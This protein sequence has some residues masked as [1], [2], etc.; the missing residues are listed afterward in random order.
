MKNTFKVS[1]IRD[2]LNQVYN[3]KISF[4]RFVEILNNQVE[5]N[6][7]F[8]IEKFDSTQNWFDWLSQSESNG[9]NEISMSDAIKDI[10]RKVNEIVDLINTLTK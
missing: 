3:E 2:L 4:S 10:S 1:Q 6:R 9:L 5:S 7:K 8:D